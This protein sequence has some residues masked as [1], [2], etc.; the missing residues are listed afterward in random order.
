M[1]IYAS[2]F[3]I[4]PNVCLFIYSRLSN[5]QLFVSC[6]HYRWHGCTFKPI[7]LSNHGFWLWGFFYVPHLLRHGISVYTVS[8]EKPAPMSHSRIRTRDVRVIRSLRRRTNRC[9]TWAAKWEDPERAR[10]RWQRQQHSVLRKWTLFVPIEGTVRNNTHPYLT[11]YP[12]IRPVQSSMFLLEQYI[13]RWPMAI[14]QGLLNR[15]RLASCKSSS[16]QSYCLHTYSWL[17]TKNTSVE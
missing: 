10:K 5:F 14:T 3:L 9:V 15:F 13:G 6:R 1:F 16:N 12:R 2:F 11:Q 4:L 8:S 17:S 7:M